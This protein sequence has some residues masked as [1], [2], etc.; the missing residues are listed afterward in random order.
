MNNKQITRIRDVMKTHFDLVDGMDTVKSALQTMI[1]VET[2]C[3]LVKKRHENDEYGMVMLSDIA[4]EVLA[5][6]RAPERVNIYEI[7][8]KPVLTVSPEMDI[9]YCAR[10]FARFDL[11]RAPVVEQH[12]EI[13]GIVSFTDM[14][15]KGLKKSN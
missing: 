10:L 5:K 11:S 3:L 13:V 1:H 15:L 6:D 14:V 12:G 9:R 2:K 4:R 7:M 8:S